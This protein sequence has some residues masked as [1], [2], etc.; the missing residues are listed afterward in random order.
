MQKRKMLASILFF[1]TGFV[2]VAQGAGPPPPQPPPP[3][4]FPIDNGIVVLFVLAIV[5]GLYK[6]YK[7]SKTKT[8]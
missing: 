2:A 6:A 4:G 1:F 5:Y 7:L 8:S 3:P